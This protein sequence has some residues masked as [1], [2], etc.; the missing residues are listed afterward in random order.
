VSEYD[1]LLCEAYRGEVFGESFFRSLAHAELGN[2]QH[3][4]LRLLQDVEAQTA[5]RLRPLIDA[6]GIDAGSEQHTATEAALLADTVREQPW[7]VFLEGLRS[8]LPEFLEKF[9][10]LQSIAADPD[11]PILVELVAHEQAIDRFAALEL[12]GRSSDAVAV[13]RDHL[14][15]SLSEHRGI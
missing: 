10:R 1:D 13:L 4:K 14:D 9:Q 7:T 12:E 6:A 8:A 15:S 2:T 11:D 3:E 5:S